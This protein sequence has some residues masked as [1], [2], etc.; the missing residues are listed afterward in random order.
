MTSPH[1]H[2]RGT[3]DSVSWEPR[4]EQKPRAIGRGGG[5]IIASFRLARAVL[6]LGLARSVAFVLSK[7][8]R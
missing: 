7:D 4:W 6:L 1:T 8:W 5:F 2:P 3:W